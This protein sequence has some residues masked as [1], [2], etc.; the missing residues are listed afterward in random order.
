MN[1]IAGHAPQ[2][3]TSLNEP[4]PDYTAS[5]GKDLRGIRLGL[6]KEYMIEGIDPQLRDAI[7]AAVKQLNSLGAE[8]VDIS[9]PST[10]YADAVYY[11][12]ARAEAS[13]NLARFDGVR[14]GYRTENPNDGADRYGRK[15]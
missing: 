9:L 13:A 2:D 15:R 6:P 5:L 1:V 8:T 7:N 14:Y 10:D 11:I 3:S 12:I 4:V